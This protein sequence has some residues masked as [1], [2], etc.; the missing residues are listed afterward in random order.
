MIR[1]ISVMRRSADSWVN[2]TQILKVAGIPKSSRTKI[3]DKEVLPGLHEKVQGGCECCLSRY[4]IV[5][6]FLDGKYQ[7]TWIP[8]ERGVELAAQYGVTSYLAP[9]FEFNPSPSGITALPV[10]RDGSERQGAKTPGT[11]MI[12]YTPSM[13]AAS[14]YVQHLQYG[15]DM[16]MW[17]PMYGTNMYYPYDMGKPEMAMTPSRN[18]G[19]MTSLAPAPDIS[20]MGLPPSHADVYIDQ[21]GQPH[22]TYATYTNGDEPPAKRQRS[23]D[24]DMGDFLPEGEE[25]SAEVQEEMEEEDSDDEE[26]APPLPNLFRLATKPLRPKANASTSRTRTKLLAAF[27]SDEPVNLQSNL[28]TEESGEMD[29]DM[30]IDDQGHTALHWAT[31]LA[32]PSITSQLVELGADINRGNYAG[33]TP[34][35]RAVLTTNYAETGDFSTLLSAIS[36][37]IQTLDQAHRSVVHHIA[38]IAGVA[39]RASSARTYMASVLDWVA[40]EGVEVGL[41]LKT[42]VDVQDIHGDTAL[43]IAARVGSKA[44]IQLLLD[45]GA[46]KSRANKLGL[47]PVDFGVEI[48][49]S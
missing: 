37:S 18:N 3:L 34:L 6:S 17:Q 30:I 48:E 16:N 42:L 27:A 10:A 40:K 13:P 21:Y 20:G 44:L 41:P 47:R 9:I 24:G 22:P 46:D 15:P 36:A 31:A 7:G 5:Y 14:P 49:A 29:V 25:E 32:K 1:G 26:E 4:M 12:A 35:I 43:N 39:G 38:L 11:G 28:G 23:D 8:F 33:E 2:A 45:A 19:S